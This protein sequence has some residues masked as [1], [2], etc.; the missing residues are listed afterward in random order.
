[1]HSVAGSGSMAPVGS[2]RHM[3][4]QEGLRRGNERLREEVDRLRKRVNYLERRHVAE[5]TYAEGIRVLREL[6]IEG[7]I[8]MFESIPAD[9]MDTTEALRKSRELRARVAAYKKVRTR[10]NRVLLFLGAIL[11]IIVML[12]LALR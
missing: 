10:V 12:A 1:M 8:G 5:K 6:D 4:G 3:P 7:A 9:V 2:Q 11:V